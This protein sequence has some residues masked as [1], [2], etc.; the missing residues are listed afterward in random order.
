[1]DGLEKMPVTERPI[2]C[3]NKKTGKIYIKDNGKWEIDNAKECGKTYKILS[4]LRSKQWLSINVWDKENP[5]WENNEKLSFE[6]C[7]IIKEMIGDGDEEKYIKQ[8]KKIMNN[9]MKKV[10]I[11]DAMNIIT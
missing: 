5:G 11:K 9:I 2:H 10:P 1:M 6:R 3:S 4:T 7:K 8:T